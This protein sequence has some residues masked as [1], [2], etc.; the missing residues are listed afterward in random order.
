MVHARAVGRIEVGQIDG[1]SEKEIDHSRIGR[2]SL[3]VRLRPTNIRESPHC[4]LVVSWSNLNTTRHTG[5]YIYTDRYK[6]RYKERHKGCG[7]KKPHHCNFN[8]SAI[9]WSTKLED[10]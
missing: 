1:N 5:A 7:D 4:V 10:C 6:D 2:E 8:I 3:S 9:V